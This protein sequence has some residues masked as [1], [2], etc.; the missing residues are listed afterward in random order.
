[1]QRVCESGGQNGRKEEVVRECEVGG[2]E[3]SAVFRTVLIRIRLW[4]LF[5]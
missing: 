1:M 5:V 2:N 4:M 3:H